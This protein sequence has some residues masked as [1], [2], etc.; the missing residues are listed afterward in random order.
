MKFVGG[1]ESHVY[2]YLLKAGLNLHVFPHND[3]MNKCQVLLLSYT[4]R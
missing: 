2:S 3:K 4:W 1:S